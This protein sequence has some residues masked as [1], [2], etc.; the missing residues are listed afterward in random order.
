MP[1]LGDVIQIVTEQTLLGQVIRNVFGYVVSLADPVTTVE[2]IADQFILQVAIVMLPM[3]TP[4][5]SSVGVSVRNLDNPE[6][7]IEKDWVGVGTNVTSGPVMPSYVASGFKLLRS[8][9]DTRNGS[10]RIAGLGEDEVTDNTWNNSGSATTLD[11][12]DALA[13]ILFALPGLTEML[14]VIIGRDP[15]T[16]QPDT[17]RISPVLE[18]QAN[19]LV[20]TQISRKAGRGE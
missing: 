10:K 2:E 16:G 18:A 8:D 20:T 13:D 14:P 1:L 5:V 3:Q 9:V 7:F 4:E 15:I 6:E 11:F 12:L 19:P 17:G